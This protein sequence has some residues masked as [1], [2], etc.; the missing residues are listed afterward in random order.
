MAFEMYLSDWSSNVCSTY[1]RRNHVTVIGKR[2][3]LQTTDGL[4]MQEV[5]QIAERHSCITLREVDVDAMAAEIYTRPDAFDVVL[6]TN[7]FCDILSNQ[8]AALAGGLG[9][10]A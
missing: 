7:M 2:H 6:T 1:L 8:A 9:L 10:A 3:V 5:D 4:F